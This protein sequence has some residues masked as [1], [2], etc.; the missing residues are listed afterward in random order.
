[1]A[2]R[3]LKRVIADCAL[4]AMREDGHHL[5]RLR[6]MREGLFDPND[7]RLVNGNATGV[8]YLPLTTSG[9]ARTGSRERLL[10]VARRYP[11]SAR[12]SG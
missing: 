9:H 7:W 4:D 10:D 2:D 11:G 8:R 5:R 6:W 1:M 3:L 12:K